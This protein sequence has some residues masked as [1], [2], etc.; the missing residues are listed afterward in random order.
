[1]AVSSRFRKKTSKLSLGDLDTM[2]DIYKRNLKVPKDVK[3]NLNIE[4]IRKG[5]WVMWEVKEGGVELFDGVNQ[6]VTTATDI[7]R[8]HYDKDFRTDF[9]YIEFDGKLYEVLK[10]D[11][12]D[13][14]NKEFIVLYCVLK[15]DKTKKVNIL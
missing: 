3:Y 14:R 12:Y 9:D 7:I 6:T 15:G 8:L 13:T 1:M 2:I 10:S 4:L 11:W 5:V